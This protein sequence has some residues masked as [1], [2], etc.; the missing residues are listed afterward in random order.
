VLLNF[1]GLHGRDGVELVP[2]VAGGLLLLFMLGLEY[3]GRELVANL[4]SA[5]PPAIAD[6]AL[7]FTPG[8]NAH[9]IPPDTTYGDILGRAAGCRLQAARPHDSVLP[10]AK[11]SSQGPVIAN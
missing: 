6:F 4:R 9:P 2:G 3:T 7:N 8:L 1:D 5:F 11:N 10:W